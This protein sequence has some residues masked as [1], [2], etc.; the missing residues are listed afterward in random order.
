MPSSSSELNGDSSLVVPLQPDD[1]LSEVILEAVSEVADQSF[2]TADMVALEELESLY[3]SV[4]SDAL[5]QLF[6]DRDTKSQLSFF[7]AGC[8]VGFVNRSHVSVT[9]VE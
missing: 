3:D 2:S 7:F 5:E 4:D 9:R 8:K 6:C 1:R